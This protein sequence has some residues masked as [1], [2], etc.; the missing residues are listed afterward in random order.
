[1]VDVSKNQIVPHAWDPEN[2]WTTCFRFLA[3][4]DEYWSEQVRHPWKGGAVDK[5]IKTRDWQE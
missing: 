5:Q 4:D 2:S 3:A 1:M